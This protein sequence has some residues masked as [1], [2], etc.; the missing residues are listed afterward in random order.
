MGH[1]EVEVVNKPSEWV[2]EWTLQTVA[3]LPE[4]AHNSRG[5][6]E[7]FMG[8]LIDAVNRRARGQNSDEWTEPSARGEVVA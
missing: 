5:L 8:L 6:L 4:F 1:E 2:D 3:H 7:L